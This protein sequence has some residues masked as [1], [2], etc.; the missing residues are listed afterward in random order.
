[1]AD[2]TTRADQWIWETIQGSVGLLDVVDDR[3][4]ADVAPGG[5]VWPAVV[6][7]YQ[8]GGDILTQETSRVLH[9]G[10]WLIRII[11]PTRSYLEM[12]PAADLLDT[13]FHSTAGTAGDGVVY[14]SV[15]EAPYRLLEVDDGVEFRHLGGLY[16]LQIQ[17]P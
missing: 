10:V 11:Q 5:T 13:L 7:Q 1:M 8:G 4:Y 2:E 6:Y 16:R 17:V 9:S 3:V 14:S 15:R 12:Q